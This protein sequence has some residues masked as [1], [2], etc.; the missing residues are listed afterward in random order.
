MGLG[1]ILCIF[2]SGLLGISARGNFSAFLQSR[3][4]LFLMQSGI[5]GVFAKGG[6]SIFWQSGGTRGGFDARGKWW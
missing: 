6:F 2:A 1:G 4:S 5:L 3:H